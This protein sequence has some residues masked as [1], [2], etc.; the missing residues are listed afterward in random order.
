MKEKKTKRPKVRYLAAASATEDGE[1]PAKVQR[2]ASSLIQ[3]SNAAAC[4][5]ELLKILAF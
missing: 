1:T 2:P 3:H 5:I 4:F